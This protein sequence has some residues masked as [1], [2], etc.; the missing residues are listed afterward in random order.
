MIINF[1]ED[2]IKV[3][4]EYGA[5]KC[6]KCGE[7]GHE[8]KMCPQNKESFPSI[9]QNSDKLVTNRNR[10]KPAQNNSTLAVSGS[11]QEKP[12]QAKSMS[13]V[14]NAQTGSTIRG[15]LR[16]RDETENGDNYEIEE[17]LSDDEPSSKNP[18]VEKQV[19]KQLISEL[20]LQY[21]Y[22]N[23]WKGFEFGSKHLKSA[24]LYQLLKLGCFSLENL[25]SQLPSYTNNSAQ[26]RKQLFHLASEI[27][28]EIV[29][30]YIRLVAE[31]LPVKINDNQ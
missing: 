4:I 19:P 30:K 27:Q 23:E 16:S 5:K 20:V 2:I 26:L 14:R 3:K 31:N 22:E 8:I 6:Y 21:C 28:N 7:R 11:T 9:V 13:D 10:V 24:Q 15:R 18:R 1:G 29:K 17:I 12:I 25:K